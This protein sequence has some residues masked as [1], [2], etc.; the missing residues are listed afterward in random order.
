LYNPQN[1]DLHEDWLVLVVLL[2]DVLEISELKHVPQAD[3]LEVKV[4]HFGLFDTRMGHNGPDLLQL[5]MRLIIIES[6][7]F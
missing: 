1:L 5:M 4:K 3:S 7:A 2:M 6:Q